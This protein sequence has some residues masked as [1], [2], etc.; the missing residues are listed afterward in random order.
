MTPADTF[1][2][3]GGYAVLFG[4]GFFDYAGG[5]ASVWANPNAHR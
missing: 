1:V 2:D 4:G 5:F 3:G